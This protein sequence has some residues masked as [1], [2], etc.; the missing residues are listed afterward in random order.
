MNFTVHQADQRS[1]EWH[2]LRLGRLTGSRA[3]EMA[4]SGKGN[5]EAAGRRNLRVQLALERITGRPHERG[6]VSA[7]MQQGA[8]REPDAASLYEALTGRMLTHTG[9]VAADSVMAGCSLDGHVGDFEGIIEIKAP[10]P[11]THLDYVK[12]GVVPS[13][14]LRQIQH[15]LWITGAQWCD[16]LSYNPEFPDAIRAKLVR[17]MRDEAAIADYAR[18]ALAFLAEVDLEVDA[19]H[20][21]TNGAA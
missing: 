5:K 1:P 16:W 8:E 12:T 18:K 4:S 10:L 2:Q 3:A 20:Q 13:D 15:G 11:A 6:Y 7:A 14:Y 19:V 9:F 21:L 17:V